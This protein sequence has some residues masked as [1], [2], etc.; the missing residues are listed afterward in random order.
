[1]SSKEYLTSVE[2]L[3]L[4]SLGRQ[5]GHYTFYRWR[6]GRIY[7]IRDPDDLSAYQRE[8]WIRS[9]RARFPHG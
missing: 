3:G 1:M 4:T 6:D 2:S 5:A 9:Y 8:I 7:P